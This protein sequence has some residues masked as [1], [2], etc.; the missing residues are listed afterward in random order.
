MIFNDNISSDFVMTL[1]RLTTLTISMMINTEIDGSD[2]IKQN[3]EQK[4]IKSFN[5][6]TINT[7]ERFSSNV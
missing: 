3:C 1:I 2:K 5:K 7:K 4:P 6:L